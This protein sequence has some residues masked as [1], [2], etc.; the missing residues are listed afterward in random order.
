MLKF[1]AALQYYQN[2]IVV[3]NEKLLLYLMVYFLFSGDAVQI[4]SQIFYE[5]STK[6]SF[7]LFSDYL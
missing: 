1:R 2:C 4:Q 6:G 7:S 3:S 5:K